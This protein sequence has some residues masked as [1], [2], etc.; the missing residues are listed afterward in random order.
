VLSVKIALVGL[1]ALASYAHALRLRPRLLAANPHP[2]GRLERRHWRLL[3]A[4]PFLSLGVVVAV[5]ALVAFP[6]P[7]QQLGDADEA[8]AAAPCDPCPLPK[9]GAGQLAIA[10]QAGPNIAAFW[11]RREDARLT[12]TMRLLDF[13][14]KPVDAAVQ[15]EGGR[16]E[17]CGTGCWRL[18]APASVAAIRVSVEAGAEVHELSVPVGWEPRRG[19]RAVRLLRRTQE[20]MRALRTLRM[21]EVLTS[22]L[23][24]VVRSGYE[25]QA[26]DRMAYRTNTGTRLVALGERRYLSTGGGPFERGRFGADGF[27]LEQFFRWT[28]YGRSVSWLGTGGLRARIA[29]FDQ[30]TPVWYRLTIDRGTDRIIEERMIAGGHFMDRRYF[31][32]NRPLSIAPPR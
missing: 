29:L 30:A 17:E 16:T 18:D 20:A 22:G 5:A 12:G 9:A 4:E 7:P 8:A 24:P 19:Q 1:I 2:E 28:I 10:E 6:L 25:F 21:R 31:D 27:R 26:P 11:L 15:L 3:G 13:S 23:G 32:F 14:A